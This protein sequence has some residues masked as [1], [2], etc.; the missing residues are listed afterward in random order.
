[1]RRFLLLLL[2]LFIMISC[3]ENKKKDIEK[4][5]VVNRK[6]IIS[7]DKKSK[8]LLSAVNSDTL[9]INY[10]C[11]VIY[12]PT[13]KSIQRSKKDVNEENFDIGLDDVLFYISESTEYLE[14]KK[15]KVITTENNKILKFNSNDKN[16]TII[17]LDLE[18][19]MFGIYLFD[20]K[21]KPKKVNIIDISDEFESYMK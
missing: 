2:G 15:I 21:Q 16:M 17:N 7:K 3:N 9:V 18:K 19:E 4:S 12:E 8:D 1:M 6:I 10:K 13:E 5:N 11:A 14:S 20:P